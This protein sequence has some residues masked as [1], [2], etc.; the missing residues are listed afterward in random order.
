MEH[1]IHYTSKD[2][3]LRI[4]GPVAPIGISEH[5]EERYSNLK[6]LCHLTN[7]LLSE[8]YAVSENS[9]DF[10]SSVS[11]SGKYAEDFLIRIRAFTNE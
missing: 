4:I 9:R 3:V 10:R 2:V 11:K 5:D 7:Q 8:I 6:E 1:E